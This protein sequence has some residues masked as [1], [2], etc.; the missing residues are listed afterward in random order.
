MQPDLASLHETG[1]Q[2]SLSLLSLPLNLLSPYLIRTHHSPNPSAVCQHSMVLLSEAESAILWVS[3]APTLELRKEFWE[4]GG[5]LQ[6]KTVA[7]R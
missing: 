4:P 2:H 5:A 7:G 1:S 3:T 6:R